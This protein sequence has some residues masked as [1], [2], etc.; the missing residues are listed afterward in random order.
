M[1]ER[2]EGER[3]HEVGAPVACRR[4]GVA[5]PP[6][7]D[8]ENLARRKGGI[9]KK[10]T[11]G[12]SIWIFFLWTRGSHGRPYGHQILCVHISTMLITIIN[13]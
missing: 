9:A 1:N 12:L 4:D 5:C 6:D 11:V 2:E 13:R 8:R 7:L 3:A 10:S